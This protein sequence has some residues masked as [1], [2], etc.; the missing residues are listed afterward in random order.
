MFDVAAGTLAWRSDNAPATR[1]LRLMSV[2]G[3]LYMY[4]PDDDVLAV[5]DNQTGNLRAARTLDGFG[6]VWPRNIAGGTIWLARD[7]AW[8]VLDAHTLE[9]VASDGTDRSAAIFAPALLTRWAITS[10]PRAR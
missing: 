5:F 10:A 9:P 1:S 3:E 6:P 8:A 2:D 4:R 7:R